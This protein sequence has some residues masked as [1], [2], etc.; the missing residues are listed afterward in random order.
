MYFVFK[1]P[2]LALVLVPASLA[3]QVR[4]PREPAGPVHIGDSIYPDPQRQWRHMRFGKM[5]GSKLYGS[6]TYVSLGSENE[7][8]NG[9]IYYGDTIYACMISFF[10]DT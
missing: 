2:Q 8:E 7:L 4:P 1:R 9:V 3:K 5:L 6:F 10:D